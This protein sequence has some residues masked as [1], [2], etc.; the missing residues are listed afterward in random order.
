MMSENGL[1]GLRN[2]EGGSNWA[3]RAEVIPVRQFYFAM[4]IQGSARHLLGNKEYYLVGIQHVLT[5]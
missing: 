1:W 3:E 5:S 4:E 2:S